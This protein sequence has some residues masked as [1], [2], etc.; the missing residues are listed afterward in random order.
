MDGVDGAVETLRAAALALRYDGSKVPHNNELNSA[1][2]DLG[3]SWVAAWVVELGH[4][5]VTIAADLRT[6]RAAK[7]DEDALTPL[8]NAAWRLGAAREKFHAVIA[9]SYGIPS[10]RI[11]D[12]AMQTL[13]FRLRIED[14]RAKLRELRGAS[15]AASRVINADGRVKAALLLRHQTAHSLAP[16]I[17]AHSLLWYE[18]ALIERGCVDHYL[19]CHLPPKGLDRM[20][21]IGSA[22]LRERATRLLEGGL[23]ALLDGMRN[24]ATLMDETAELEPPPV[25]W[26]AMETNRCYYTRAEASDASRAA[27]DAAPRDGAGA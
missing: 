9:L 2:P 27:H 26:K 12:D 14:T 1:W 3:R 21:D 18:A 8:E 19:S 20:R 15:E 22:S 24:L 5:A 16:L 25:L 7:T 17:K 6:A 10:L 13:T 4:D 11:G 23:T